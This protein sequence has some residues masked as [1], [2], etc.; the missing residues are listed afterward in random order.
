M[1]NSSRTV[2][3]RT[4]R[5]SAAGG[6]GCSPPTPC[7]E[8]SPLLL[9]PPGRRSRCL[10][11]AARGKPARP[12]PPPTAA[13]PPRGGRQRPSGG[14]APR[15]FRESARSLGAGAVSPSRPSRP[16]AG[17][18][19]PRPVSGTARARW[20]WVVS[21]WRAPCWPGP[22]ILAHLRRCR[23]RAPACAAEGL[24]S[25]LGTGGPGGAS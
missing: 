1:E 25:A 7:L 10:T 23:G 3:S 18:A 12:H 8:R 4:L 5:P 6:R 17:S 2:R 19:P 20:V 11:R 21:F 9:L 14:L 24:G 15:P 16:G 13:P 22:R